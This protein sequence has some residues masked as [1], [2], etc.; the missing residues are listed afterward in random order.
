MF[1][2]LFFL[3]SLIGQVTA[4]DG[5][6]AWLRYAPIPDA[7]SHADAIPSIV[8]SLNSTKSSPVH[9][10][11][12]E[13]AQ[14]IKGIVGKDVEVSSQLPEEN[15]SA[16][17][18]GTLSGYQQAG[19]LLS[20]APDLTGDGFWLDTRQ[21]NVLILG[22][23]ERGALYGAF[24][25]LSML[26]QGNFTEVAY[27]NNPAAPIRWVNQWDNLDGSIERGYA[28]ASIFFADGVVKDDLARVVEYARLMASIGINGVIINN[29]NADENMLNSTNIAGLGRIA[30]AIRPYGV[31]AGIA[32]NF[33]SP[34]ATLG[35]FD[36][37]DAAVIQWWTNTIAVIYE[38][39][40]DLAGFLVKGDSK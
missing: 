19:G 9:T 32:L 40:P 27:A 24:E 36:P 2:E 13:L 1:R 29:V 33:A 30:D 35:T 18:V 11:G 25:Y 10:A 14:G 39:V 26:A 28:G 20:A 17:T 8:V 38:T 15:G 6:A 23:N 22:Q 31:Q 21:G 16:I 5:L 4:E 37:L 7:A 12:V 34:N 3:A